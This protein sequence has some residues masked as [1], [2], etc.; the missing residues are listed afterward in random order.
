LIS[1]NALIV[2]FPLVPSCETNGTTAAKPTDS[3][4]YG[5]AEKIGTVPIFAAFDTRGKVITR[6]GR[7]RKY[8][9]TQSTKDEVLCA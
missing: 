8:Y 9:V 4:D 6:Y 1:T 2:F 3:E 7:T 5:T